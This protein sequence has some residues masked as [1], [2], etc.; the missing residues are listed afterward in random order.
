MGLNRPDGRGYGPCVIFGSRPLTAV[1][2]ILADIA[3]VILAGFLLS[4]Q[5]A[6]IIAI[7]LITFFVRWWQRSASQDAVA[8][9]GK[10]PTS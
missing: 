9:S 7:L 3:V 5:L 8:R 1:L 6:A 4:P 2:Q 10:P